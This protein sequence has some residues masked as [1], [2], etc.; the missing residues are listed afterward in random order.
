[1]TP[2]ITSSR[3]LF[4]RLD[5]ELEPVEAGPEHHGN[6][7]DEAHHRHDE[8]HRRIGK[9]LLLSGDANFS[10]S[11]LPKN[12]A[13]HISPREVVEKPPLPKGIERNG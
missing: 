10:K 3:R 1:L 6:T 4:E 5:A 2:T 13:M 8:G 12:A 7:G 11:P 9:S